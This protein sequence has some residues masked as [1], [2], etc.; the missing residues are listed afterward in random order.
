VKLRVRLANKLPVDLSL[1]N[2][3]VQMEPAAHFATQ[4]IALSLGPN[5]TR[6]VLL[7]TQPLQLGEFVVLLFC[8]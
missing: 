4:N 7:T 1:T 2:L 5:T 6:D 8:V 3:C